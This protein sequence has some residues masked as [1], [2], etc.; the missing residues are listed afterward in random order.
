VI[1]IFKKFFNEI[2]KTRK[3]ISEKINNLIK[4]FKKID[5]SF[6]DELE[7]ILI[8]SDV[9]FKASNELKTLVKEDIKKNKVN[10][11][12]NIK[13]ILIKKIIDILG[14]KN[15]EL[16]I[17]LPKV[18]LIIGVNGSGKTT[19]VAK[20]G[21]FFKLQN[22][23]VLLAAADTFRA[24]AIDQL[25]IWSKKIKI[26]IIK[27]K[28]RSDPGA[29]VY[30]AIKSAKSKNIDIL[31]CDTAGRLHNKKNL[32]NEL[33]K[34]FKIIRLEYDEDQIEVLISIDAT[35]GQN[36]LQQV[37]LFNEILKI[38][39]IILNK[40]DG[41]S[42]GGVVIALGSEFKIPIKFVGIGEK[43]SDIRIFDAQ[44]FSESLLS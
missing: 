39:G 19:S 14:T 21:N 23:S 40:L 15:S 34:I 10:D 25:E 7:E 35:M 5:D 38:D 13:K 18:I 30:D 22:K 1:F 43:I 33:A 26:N 8:A 31:I 3:N 17:K 16:K 6:F 44:S 36:V 24:A 28:E 29:V 2:S 20:I 41:T 11:S 32:T 27:H 4:K 37:R 9:G 12:S 42:K